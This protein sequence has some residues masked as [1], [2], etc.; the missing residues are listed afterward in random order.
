M[1]KL[2]VRND[3]PELTVDFCVG[4]KEYSLKPSEQITI[5]A[6]DG[7]YVYFDAIQV[8]VEE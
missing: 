8:E 2:H 5:E 3:N 1:V 6:N 4:M 7:D